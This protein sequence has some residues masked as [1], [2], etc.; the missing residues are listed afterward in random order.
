MTCAPSE[1]SDQPGHPPSLIRVFAVR[2]KKAWVLSYPLNAQ[3]RLWSDWADAQADLSS[4]GTQSFCW[5]CLE[6]EV[7]YHPIIK[8][9]LVLNKYLQ[10]FSSC[11]QNWDHMSYFLPM[12]CKENSKLITLI[13]LVLR[14]YGQTTK[15]HAFPV[16]QMTISFKCK[17][18]N[19]FFQFLQGVIRNAGTL[20]NHIQLNQVHEAIKFSFAASQCKISPCAYWQKREKP[21]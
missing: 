1:D 20:K 19:F 13:L 16:F 10:N 18:R 6:A 5:F 14:F 12:G 3:R 11:W 9:P 8:T 21:Y 17:F 2:M 15:T 7:L 4:L